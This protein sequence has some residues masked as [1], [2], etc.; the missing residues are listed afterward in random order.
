MTNYLP[1]DIRLYLRIEECK[2][3][4]GLSHLTIGSEVYTTCQ[5]G[6]QI[7]THDETQSEL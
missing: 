1:Q 5:V 7:I 2:D 3:L 4:S 6:P